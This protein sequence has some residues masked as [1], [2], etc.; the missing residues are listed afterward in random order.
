MFKLL[1]RNSADRI[2]FEDFST[3]EF[4]TENACKQS[5]GAVVKQLDEE[6]TDEFR[7]N[8]KLDQQ[9][10]TSNEAWNNTASKLKYTLKNTLVSEPQMQSKNCLIN[11]T[12]KDSFQEQESKIFY[13]NIEEN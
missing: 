3:H 9:D 10:E 11:K 5:S 12:L 4:L 1:K 7:T 8:L 13:Q 2:N 6:I